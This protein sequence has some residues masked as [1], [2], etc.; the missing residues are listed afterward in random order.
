MIANVSKTN[1]VKLFA[2]FAM[3]AMVIAGAAVVLSDNGVDAADDTQ[4]YSGVIGKD[5]HQEFPAG[6]NVIIDKKLTI[7]EKGSLK[8]IDGNLTVN[9][10]VEVIIQKGGSL[11]VNG[12]VTINGD[13]KVTDETSSFKVISFPSTVSFSPAGSAVIATATLSAGLI[14]RCFASIF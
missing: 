9:E 2:L 14:F 3:L 4:Y 7:T 5:V 13:V 8:V 6:T 11:I 1:G 10:G 12:L